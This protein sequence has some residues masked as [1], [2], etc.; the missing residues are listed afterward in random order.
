MPPCN[1]EQRSQSALQSCN[2]VRSGLTQ[3]VNV[4]VGEKLINN[5][6]LKAKA[7]G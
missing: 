5:K 7:S 2:R 4:R 1:D 6:P 3:E